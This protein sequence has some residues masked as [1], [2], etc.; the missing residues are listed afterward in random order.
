MKEIRMMILAAFLG[1]A[2]Y[3]MTAQARDLS[4]MKG[5]PSARSLILLKEDPI[6]LKGP[7]VACEVAGGESFDEGAED[8]QRQLKALTEEL[9]RLERGVKEKVRKEILPR[10]RREI[11]RLREWLRNVSPEKEADAPVRT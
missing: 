8:F 10:I 5:L 7:L 6:I 1:L 4:E 11:Q 2:F 3:S 9:K